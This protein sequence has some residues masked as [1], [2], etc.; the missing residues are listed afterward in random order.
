MPKLETLL[1]EEIAK[2]MAGIESGPITAFEMG[3]DLVAAAAKESLKENVI[4]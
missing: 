1:R 4:T 2:T 3:D